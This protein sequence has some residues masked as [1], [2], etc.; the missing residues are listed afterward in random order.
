MVTV[1]DLLRGKPD[2][3]WIV[4]PHATVYE[5]L[6]ILAEK[7]VGALPVVE[8]QALRGIFSERDYA[9]RVALRGRSSRE[10][11][12]SDLMVTAVV[13]VAPSDSIQDCMVL[14]TQKRVRHLPVLEGDRLIGI[15][16]IGDVVKQIITEQ[17]H[18][19]EQL[20]SYIRGSY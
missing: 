7:D 8:G 17:K 5:A 6:E 1:Q 11:R 2:R 15:V 4:S 3:L 10:T 16:T 14:M 9:R 13:C 20:E 19:I 12:V 18:T